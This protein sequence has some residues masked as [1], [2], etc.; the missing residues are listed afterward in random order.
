MYNVLYDG[1]K[2]F[3]CF[4]FNYNEAIASHSFHPP[5]GQTAAN[6]DLPSRNGNNF[7]SLPNNTIHT[8]CRQIW[9]FSCCLS[10]PPWSSAKK[11]P[12][13]IIHASLWENLKLFLKSKPKLI[14]KLAL[15]DCLDRP[16]RWGEYDFVRSRQRERRVHVRLPCDIAS[17][18]SWHDNLCLAFA[19]SA[20]RFQAMFSAEIYCRS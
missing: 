3:L 19:C 13:S 4:T 20:D 5:G 7:S 17:K 15:R 16:E 9:I 2:T 8:C 18:V 6:D 1:E 11:F 10:S 14:C 12:L